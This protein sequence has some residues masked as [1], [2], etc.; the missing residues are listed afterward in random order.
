MVRS[1][2]GGVHLSPWGWVPFVFFHYVTYVMS[3]WGVAVGFAWFCLAGRDN[4]KCSDSASMFGLSLL[5]FLS[6][7]RGI[8]RW[9]TV[10]C[11]GEIMGC[12]VGAGMEGAEWCCVVL[13]LWLEAVWV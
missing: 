4:S 8:I 13:S 6:C 1:E 3:E 12:G 9:W 11:K 10:V 7:S 5:I 2:R